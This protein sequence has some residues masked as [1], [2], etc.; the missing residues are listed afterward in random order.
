MRHI[1]IVGGG[2]AGLPL[3][4]GLLKAGHKVRLV[5]N[6]TAADLAS[7]K[8]MSSQCVFGTAR[9]QERKLGLDIWNDTAPALTGMRIA[10][11]APD[12][13][14]KAFGFV[15]SLAEPAQSV[16]QRVKFPRFMQAVA[17]AGGTV[18]IA[19]AGIPELERYA[20]D[21]DLV[22]IAAGKGDVSRLFERD[23]ARSPYDKPMRA[24]SLVYA[25]G[26]TPYDR[27][28]VTA[29]LIPGAGELFMIP[30][31]T[32]TGPCE[33]LFMEA[34]PGGPLD[35]FDSA[36]D[37]DAHLAK[38][39]ALIKQFV[40]WEYERVRDATA[41]DANGSLVGRFPPTVRKGVG[42]LPS[43]KPVLG[44]ADAVVLN[45]PIVGQGA[46]NAIKAATTYLDAIA[47]RGNAPFDA[48]WMNAT[49]EAAFKRV[50]ASTMFSN[51]FLMP[52]PPHVI[53]LFARAPA[54]QPLADRLAEGFDEPAGVVPLFADPALA[55]AA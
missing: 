9:A 35:A 40:P 51:M 28:C 2:Q 47:Q 21:S 4:V 34:G 3:A 45:D 19:E 14:G 5:Q 33:I 1:T 43:G 39:K 46:N 37:A 12:G 11:A 16:D 44:L 18:E 13:S 30:A 29:N 55:A 27:A 31:L 36:D 49:F 8:A 54:K 24:L 23:A 7:G 32:H 20:K 50:E 52:P 38:I 22:I 10:I 6:R 53:E 17:D 26:V 48:A 15:G 41:T 42:A 25:K